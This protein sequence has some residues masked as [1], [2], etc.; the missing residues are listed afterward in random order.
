MN[1]FNMQA[2]SPF[3]NL[4]A[5]GAV[6]ALGA[7]LLSGRTMGQGLGMGFQGAQAALQGYHQQ[8]QQQTALRGL[9]GG[10]GLSPQQQ[11]VLSAMPA[12]QA[13]GILS[14]QA[15]PKFNKDQALME[16][17]NNPDTPLG[18]AA[19]VE[20]GLEA[21][22]DTRV[23]Q[24]GLNARHNTASASALLGSQDKAKDR[25]LKRV[26]FTQE[27]ANEMRRFSA[28]H[29]LDLRKLAMRAQEVG[30]SQAMDEAR[31]GLDEKKFGLDERK[32][33]IG[34][35]QFGQTFDRGVIEFNAGHR[36]KRD[37]FD[38]GKEVDTLARDF[39]ERGFSADEAYRAAT[40]EVQR[41]NAET[42]DFRAR[43]PTPTTAVRNAQA[44]GLEPGTAEFDEFIKSAG[45][46]STNVTV[47]GE[48]PFTEAQ[49][50]L[51][52]FSTMMD[53]VSPVIDRLESGFTRGDFW[54]KAAGDS[55]VANALIKSPEFRQ[56]ESA[57]RQWV[58]GILRITTGA[59]A[60]EDETRR[61]FRTYFPQ[62]G[63]DPGTVAFKR[64]QRRAIEASVKSAGQG[65]FG[66]AVA[67]DFSG[68]GKP[69]EV[70][71]SR[72]LPGG[73][74]IKRKN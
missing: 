18:R 29:G 50:R 38:Y 69:L 5:S 24:G 67:P 13:L 40:L 25:D 10:S 23:T 66:A 20:F 34:V 47:N 64:Q 55:N 7:G 6:G 28:T 61:N 32:V 70:G 22:A 12:P 11:A 8:Q 44:I 46:S 71:G 36:L 9:L 56:Y 48:K 17:L 43:N 63:D 3:G 41:K 62:P 1:I 31:F 15:F 54:K 21:D 57:G 42:A 52:L 30:H 4:F 27:Q 35:D 68:F 60:T 16:A 73:V 72:E 53:S 19:R 74:T 2:G 59:A 45:K 49:A 26:Q 14:G 51:S 65:R 33:D 37:E 58:E 39:A